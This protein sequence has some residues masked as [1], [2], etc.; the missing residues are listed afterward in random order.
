MNLDKKFNLMDNKE[1]KE[2]DELFEKSMYEESQRWK[3]AD[4]DWKGKISNEKEDE[5][6]RTDEYIALK[7]ISKKIG[8]EFNDF[9]KLKNNDILE[10]KYSDNFFDKL[11][12]NFFYKGGTARSA[13]ERALGI[14]IESKPRDLDLTHSKEV[15]DKKKID[16]IS[17]KYMPDDFENNYGSEELEGD[18]F[19]TR[20]FTFNEVLFDGRKIM[21]TKE[22]V[23][24]L[25]T[26][27]IRITEFEKE[28]NKHGWQ[29]SEMYESYFENILDDS[30]VKNGKE[31][32]YSYE[33]GTDEE[34]DGELRKRIDEYKNKKE[35]FLKDNPFIKWKLLAK[36]VRFIAE[37]NI[38]RDNVSNG[39]DIDD[40]ENIYKYVKSLGIK[41]FYVALH[42]DRAIETGGRE[43]GEKYIK[44]MVY[45]GVLEED[46]LKAE[47]ILVESGDYLK[48]NI[49]NFKMEYYDQM[50]KEEN[51]LY[52][53]IK[54]G[55][56]KS[57]YE[58]WGESFLK[59]NKK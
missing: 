20:D 3:K 1:L 48:K 19:E 18:Y 35:K 39:D 28:E 13:L 29:N 2:E 36:A 6:F 59:Y 43:L 56:E 23:V 33:Y 34:I 30:Y 54:T 44:Q 52:K 32:Y 5:I 17:K 42:L 15:K 4:M 9:L 51:D 7:E 53:N 40:Y 31:Y 41:E 24:D 57:D 49:T 22:A 58:E 12:K 38:K 16:E 8:I 11:P 21:A 45:C 26:K 27:K 50:I 25:Y 55:E 14:D 47:D 10:I 37:K 46:I